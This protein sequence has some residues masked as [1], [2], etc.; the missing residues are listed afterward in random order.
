LGWE[1]FFSLGAWVRGNLEN[2]DHRYFYK[3]KKSNNLNF[4]LSA[5]PFEDCLYLESKQTSV[6]RKGKKM[7]KDMTVYFT[8]QIQ[9]CQILFRDHAG[10]RQVKLKL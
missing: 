9:T 6:K 8:L 3:V 2:Q 4:S 7:V 1:H 10:E 5:H